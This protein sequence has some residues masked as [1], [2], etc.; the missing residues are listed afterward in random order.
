LLATAKVIAK[1]HYTRLYTPTQ[2]IVEA[3]KLGLPEIPRFY[4]ARLF[5]VENLVLLPGLPDATRAIRLA[6]EELTF[7]F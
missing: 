1:S 2:Q 4:L 7:S 3:R 5:M 6:K